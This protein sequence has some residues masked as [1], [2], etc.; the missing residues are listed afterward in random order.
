ML[1]PSNNSPEQQYPQNPLKLLIQ[2]YPIAFWGGLWIV[3]IGVGSVATLGLLNPGPIAQETPNPTPAP[4]AVP[5]VTPPQ[6]DFQ[7][8]PS[9][10]IFVAIAIGCATGSVLF[11]YVLINSTH[12]PRSSKRLRTVATTSK[13]RRPVSRKTQP[14]ATQPVAQT[15]D[16]NLATFNHQLPQVTVLPPNETHPLDRGEESLAE[17]LDLRKRQS[18]ASLMHGK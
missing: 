5:I 13:K 17:L 9:L 14:V 4:A 12:S 6:E 15:F 10:S 1:N 16:N 3:L 18:L 2:K 8:Y 11:T 7:F